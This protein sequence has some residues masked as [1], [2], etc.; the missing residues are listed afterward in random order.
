MNNEYEKNF[1]S[2]FIKK[3]KRPRIEYE[4]ANINKRK[5]VLSRFCHNSLDYLEESKVIF[6]GNS[7]TIQEINT[8]IKKYTQEKK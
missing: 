8:L 2:K 5:N 6:S 7:I 4:L 3:N 1:I